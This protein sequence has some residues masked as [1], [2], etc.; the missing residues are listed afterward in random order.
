[1]NTP[2]TITT[3][4]QSN[5][6][7]NMIISYQ[8]YTGNATATSDDLFI[9]LSHPTSEREEFL[10]IH[11]ICNYQVQEQIVSPNYQVK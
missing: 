8:E 3:A 1:M 5:D 9:F 6:I 11:C 10:H 4:I 2:E 7:E